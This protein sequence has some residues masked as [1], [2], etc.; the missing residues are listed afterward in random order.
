MTNCFSIDVEGFVESNVES[1]EIAPAY[2][3]KA[4]ENYEIE[5]NVNVNSFW[6]LLATFR[7]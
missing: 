6:R 2:I 1:F 5:K 4:K 3:D 7:R